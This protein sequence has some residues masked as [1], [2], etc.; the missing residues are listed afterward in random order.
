MADLTFGVTFHP[1][2]VG[3]PD[4]DVVIEFAQAAEE[5]G[6]DSLWVGDH[7]L[8]RTPL[9][10]PLTLLAAVATRT[11]RIRLGTGVLLLPLRQPTVVA[12]MVATL[13]YL[14]RGRVIL[15]V[16]VGGENP[17]EFE[18]CG[19][20]PGERGR[21]T[22]EGIEILRRLWTESSASF[23]GQFW[24]FSEVDLQPK[25]VQQ[26][27]PPVWIGGR[28]EAALRRAGRLGDGWID[29]FVTPQGFRE[30]MAR[31]AAHGAAAGRAMDSFAAAHV[32]MTYVAPTK[33]EAK[34]A[35]EQYL[36]HYYDHA[37]RFLLARYCALGTPEDCIAKVQR[38][39]EAGARYIVLVP[40]CGPESIVAQ[41]E[42]LAR[43]VVAAFR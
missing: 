21:R 2:P 39:A 25:P 11:K 31:I 35:T 27:C 10:E 13:D 40:T 24:R 4:P 43:E 23:A 9:L 36:S 3:M 26:P 34:R 29:Y 38:F 20:P 7:I 32:L 14:S 15:G 41:L 8:W 6:F 5:L 30:S 28:S 18:A 42:T 22:D 37:F 33:D 17:K 1:Y 19:V 12:K 16:G